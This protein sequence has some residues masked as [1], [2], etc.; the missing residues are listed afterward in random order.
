MAKRSVPLCLVTVLSTTVAGT[1]SDGLLAWRFYVVSGRRRYALWAACAAIALNTML[2]LSSNFQFLTFYTH[3]AEFPNMLQV[4]YELN[5]A[6]GWCMLGI[7]TVLSSLTIWKIVR[8]SRTARPAPGSTG[9][10]RYSV[11][12]E[13]IAESALVTWIGLV[14]YG[15]GSLAPQGKNTTHWDIGYVIGCILPMFFGISQ[16]LITARLGFA[17]DS[18]CSPDAERGRGLAATYPACGCARIE[19]PPKGIA[20][21][22]KRETESVSVDEHGAII[23][24]RKSRAELYTTHYDEDGSLSVREPVVETT[25]TLPR[26]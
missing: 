4:T 26:S 18:S 6:W 15:V 9:L 22:V 7:N 2:G 12:V 10:G 8:V 14:L 11:V 5:A 3:R 16:C 13:A 21:M 24:E 17:F 23:E 20:I 1:L 19:E 25:V